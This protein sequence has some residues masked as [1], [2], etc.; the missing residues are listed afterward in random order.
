VHVAGPGKVTVD[1]IVNVTL[2]AIYAEGSQVAE[3]TLSLAI[4]L[5]WK[6]DLKGV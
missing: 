6:Y 5:A 1:D 4:R 2:S 3:S